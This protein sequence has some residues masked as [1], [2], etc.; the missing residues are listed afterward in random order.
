MAN[1]FAPAAASPFGAAQPASPFGATSAFGASATP[2][3]PFGQAGTS[4]FGGG[5][6][7]GSVFG[8]TSAPAFGATSTPA[9]GAAASTPAFGS[10]A[11]PFGGGSSL[12]GQ[13][14]KPAAFGTFGQ[15]Q[16]SPFGAPAFGQQSQ[17]AFGAGG[18]FGSTAT[19]P[20]F[21][22]ATGAA[23]AFGAAAPAFGASAPAFGATATTPAFG[24]ASAPAFGATGGLFGSTGTSAFGAASAP[25]FGSLSSPS[26]GASAPAFGATTFGATPFG[27]AAAAGT[28]S[29]N[30]PYAPTNDTETGT[31]G[32]LGKF[33]SIS[34]MPAYKNKSPEELRWE[35]YQRGDKGGPAPA[36]AGGGL[37]GQPAAAASPFG[38]AAAAPA[39]G[40]APANPFGQASTPSLF[41]SAAPAFGAAAS[42]P[43][44]GASTSPS[45]FGSSTPAFGAASSPA[46]GATGGSLFGAA[47]ATASSP[48]GAA[49]AST[50]SLFGSPAA[51]TASPFGASTGASLFGATTGAAGQP[52][53]S[54]F[55]ASSPAFGASAFGTPGAA[56]ATPAF[57]ATPSLFGTGAATGGG[58]FGSSTP[59]AGSTGLGF[60][61]GTAGAAG[62]APG[63]G[64]GGS[65]FGGAAGA[66]GTTGAGLF[67]ASTGSAFGFGGAFQTKPA[68][69]TQSSAFPS[70]GG[71]G[72]ST[73]TPGFGA[74]Q[75]AFG[76]GLF[77]STPQLGSSPFGTS[78]GATATGGLFGQSQ[79][80]QQ[81]QQQ[82]QQQQQQQLLQQLQQS[83]LLQ[84]PFGVLPAMPNFGLSVSAGVGVR[85][86]TE[87]GISSM[88]AS[89][90]YASGT[91]VSSI[92]TPRRITPR[93]RARMHHPATR[94]FHPGR[95]TARVPF[96]FS[97]PA[98][99]D[100]ISPAVP[101][102]DALFVPRDNPRALF[103]RHPVAPAAGADASPNGKSPAAGG[104]PGKSGSPVRGG[105]GVGGSPQG[106]DYQSPPSGASPRD[107]FYAPSAP[108]YDSSD[109][110]GNGGSQSPRSPSA[111]RAGATGGG[112]GSAM[113][114]PTLSPAWNGSFSPPSP[115][116]GTATGA[117]G[118]G[119]ESQLP[120]L[121][122]ADYFTEPSL[123]ALA[124]LERSLPG[125]LAR[126]RDF[127][128]G[129]KGFG[130]VRFLG[131]TDVRGLDV[132][133]I[134]QFHKCEILVYMD[135][136]SK[137]P[138]GE[139]LNKPAEVTLLQVVCVDKKTGKAVTEGP[140][141][142]RFER[143]LRRKT[144]E[145]EAEFLSFNAA[146]GE[147]RFKVQHFS[148]V[149]VPPG[150]VSLDRALPAQLGIDPI[151]LQQMRHVMFGCGAGDDDNGDDGEGYNGG[152]GSGIGGEEG[153]GEVL[154]SE[155]EGEEGEKSGEDEE[156]EG[157]EKGGR[158]GGRE[159]GRE[160]VGR[161]LVC[162]RQ[163]GSLA[164]LCSRYSSLAVAAAD[165]LAAARAKAGQGR[166]V[167]GVGRVVSGVGVSERQLQHEQ[168]VWQLV[169]VLFSDWQGRRRSDVMQGS[170]GVEMGGEFEGGAGD[171]SGEKAGGGSGG[172]SG[173]G[174]MEEEEEE[175]D[176][177]VED[178]YGAMEGMSG[179]AQRNGMEQG[180]RVK[181]VR[182]EATLNRRLFADDDGEEEEETQ[183]GAA[184]GA[185]GATRQPQWIG[186]S[187]N[188]EEEERG[189]EEEEEEEEEEEQEGVTEEE[190]VEEEEEEE[191]GDEDEEE[192]GE[193]EQEEYDEETMALFRRAE[194]GAWLQGVVAP[195][196]VHELNSLATATTAANPNTSFNTFTTNSTAATTTM[197]AETAAEDAAAL[198]LRVAFTALTGMQVETAVGAAALTGDVRLAALLALA[199]SAP[200]ATRADA[201]R[202]LALWERLAG[203]KGDREG[204]SRGEAVSLEKLAEGALVSVERLRLLRL[205]GGDVTGALEGRPLDWKRHLGLLMWFG[206]PPA[207]PLGSVIGEFRRRVR[208]GR[209]PRAIPWYEETIGVDGGERAEWERIGGG[210]GG[211]ERRRKEKGEE[212]GEEGVEDSI[213]AVRA[214]EVL[215]AVHMDYVAQLLA[216]N[217]PH[218]ALYC[219]Q[220][221]PPCRK[222]PRWALERAF[223]EVLAVSCPV[224]AAS[225]AQRSFIEGQLLVPRSWMCAAQAVHH[226]YEGRSGDELQCL[227][228]S[229]Q[230]DR[231][232]Q[233]F[234]N[235]LGLG[236]LDSGSLPVFPCL[237]ASG[238][239]H[240]SQVQRWAEV[241]QLMEGLETHGKA[242]YGWK[243]GGRL[244]L[245][246]MHLSATL[247]GQAILPTEEL[248]V[249]VADGAE[250]LS[251]FSQR[252][253]Q[254]LHTF[255]HDAARLRM[256][257]ARMLDSLS[258]SFLTHTAA[259]TAAADDEAAAA[260][261]AAAAAEAAAAASPSAPLDA[262]LA[263]S[264]L[265]TLPRDS[266]LAFTREA[267]SELA[268]WLAEVAPV[269]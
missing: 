71:L 102:A 63:F 157:E 225:E 69:L 4:L 266:R 243:E 236:C 75:P 192:A 1:P 166:V 248:K 183:G 162:S 265:P 232:H 201:A 191:E 251:E 138:V 139:E 258:R 12:F 36:Q 101:R 52:G 233:L 48:F 198:P 32:Q 246:Y 114:S 142:E 267:A 200:A 170:G 237:P 215:P 261:A 189:S 239:Q 214:N 188:V 143:K 110:N 97:S 176:G 182:E 61:F 57:G 222:L 161:R 39:F 206:M 47:G 77:G 82:L 53:A 27:A 234:M 224:W 54:L 74:S 23:P 136:Q 196:I 78:L 213:G 228:G 84:S 37:F 164:S 73:T 67:G 262:A 229:F 160:W 168:A 118:P 72:A 250:A 173:D 35:D 89:D 26:F 109:L 156:M 253:A 264:A 20:T 179:G 169:D 90:R 235:H 269:Q 172:K 171:G 83:G 119:I 259:A 150:G 30:P 175:R 193:G 186:G 207:S 137:P 9:F 107:A 5:A 45:I 210:T 212:E 245:D 55:G 79:Q 223:R 204:A 116:R 131:E 105:G 103:I 159:E 132:E 255:P 254:S 31:A 50:P 260:A 3:S 122:S 268:S 25:A 227:L 134:V 58:L 95:D 141:V 152:L 256:V 96:F 111:A 187:A 15:T 29:R 112:F 13:Q 257:Y 80:Q 70:F 147:W 42:T 203:G 7:T 28:G 163:G 240:F 129:R 158:E 219:L 106:S 64:A 185:A 178:G 6:A 197:R 167:S 8:A 140:E 49:A 19:T 100:D 244:L 148:R 33:I 117:K 104:T 133:A 34:A 92:L 127:V 21:G 202:Q 180:E 199:H 113:P 194:F 209:V 88:P 62:S 41:G 128:V 14:Q 155:E 216:A 238:Q 81:Q 99:H 211:G 124:A 146:K 98:D 120:Q 252:T 165:A 17:P 231:A 85:A 177:E 94:H 46:F 135:E 86:S 205:V 145:Q 263:T 66:G 68:G 149:S 174:S 40:S 91:R 87:L 22:A 190:E 217:Q 153:D 181:G 24:A 65:L 151:R 126:V 144:A 44:F 11:S 184:A 10:T 195:A 108:P 123:S 121:K 226:R 56:A 38:A 76:G 43:A 60:G 220:H 130:S 249:S 93:T 115:S 154:Q 221:V 59:A 51:A 18:A 241:Q 125:S 218:W 242:I 208:V 247:E 16:A 2:A 230:W